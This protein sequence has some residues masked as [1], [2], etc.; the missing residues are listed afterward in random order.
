MLNLKKKMI[1]FLE[2]ILRIMYVLIW[3]DSLLSTKI[4]IKCVFTSLNRMELNFELQR[5]FSEQSPAEEKKQKEE[6]KRYLLRKL[7]F[8]PTVDELK[9]KKVIKCKKSFF[10]NLYKFLLRYVHSSIFHDISRRLIT[11]IDCKR[12]RWIWIKSIFYRILFYGTIFW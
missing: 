9:E 11:H 5:S 2:F 6:K 1:N 7:S 12:Y 3:Y 8:R 4:E 10:V